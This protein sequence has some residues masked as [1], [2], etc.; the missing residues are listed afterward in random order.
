MAVLLRSVATKMRG[1]TV[2]PR[3]RQ[4]FSSSSSAPSGSTPPPINDKNLSQNK[5]APGELHSVYLF[6]G[7]S[8]LNALRRER[9]ILIK[10]VEDCRREHIQA[11]G[12]GKESDGQKNFLDD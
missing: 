1:M 2:S 4:P 10:A 3:A 7:E 11:K 5:N 12:H 6:L 8:E 9:S